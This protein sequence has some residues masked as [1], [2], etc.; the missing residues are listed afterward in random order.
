MIGAVGAAYYSAYAAS[1]FGI[2][3]LGECLRQEIEVLDKAKHIHICTVMPATIDTPFFHHAANYTGRSVNAM[4]PVYPVEQAAKTMVRLAQRPQREVF[5]G[6]AA[7]M[8]SF[9]HTFAPALTEPMMAKQV[10]KT[11]FKPEPALS[12]SGDVF[13]PL[14]TGTGISDGWQGGPRTVTRSAIGGGVAVAASALLVWSW[15]RSRNG[16]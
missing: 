14:P 11:D 9:L 8:I 16:H 12:T 6:N 4:P 10:D 15:V 13:E 1:K 2:R 7:R 5:V 3:A